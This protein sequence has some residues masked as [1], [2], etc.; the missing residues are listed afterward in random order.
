MAI[1]DLVPR[2]RQE[3]V[4]VR[5]DAGSTL[6]Q[7]HREIDRMFAGFFSDLG[8]GLPGPLAELAEAG[9]WPRVNVSESDKDVVV[10]AELPGMEQ[11]DVAVEVDDQALTLRGETYDERETKERR[12]TRVERRG[13]SFQRVIALPTTVQTDQVKATFKHGLLT[14][15]L[16][17]RE[18][19]QSRR[20]QVRIEVGT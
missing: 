17:K 10:T 14:V 4:A 12:W 18:P 16:P 5:H 13:G 1:R 7:F 9:G 11:K 8:L 2:R 6:E 19:E 3:S 15:T 20:K